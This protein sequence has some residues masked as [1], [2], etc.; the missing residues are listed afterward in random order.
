MWRCPWEMMELVGVEAGGDGTT[1]KTVRFAGD[2]ITGVPP[3]QFWLTVCQP[4]FVHFDH[5]AELYFCGPGRGRKA[6]AVVDATV[7]K[8]GRV[9]P[10]RLRIG[11]AVGVV[12]HDFAA[13]P[14]G[15]L[16]FARYVQ[17]KQVFVTVFYGYGIA[18]TGEGQV[19][20]S[21][22]A[23]VQ[24][25]PVGEAELAAAG[26]GGEAVVLQAAGRTVVT[27]AVLPSF[28]WR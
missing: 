11:A 9:L 3:L 23:F 5:V 22:P 7:V 28:F 4:T 18:P 27:A 12:D 20:K 21:Q 24:P 10:E 16:Q 25:H 15:C 6:L 8:I 14:L 2:G 26:R 19:A 17:A 13:L 1:G